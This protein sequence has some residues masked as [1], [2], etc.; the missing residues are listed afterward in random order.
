M[1]NPELN[2]KLDDPL[3]L[4]S[5]RTIKEI[6]N[7]NYPAEAALKV[8]RLT[9][10][11]KCDE[12]DD[13]YSNV[14]ASYQ[15]LITNLKQ[16]GE[17]DLEVAEMPLNATL[18][19]TK[20]IFTAPSSTGRSV[21]ANASFIGRYECDVLVKP[22]SRSQVEGFLQAFKN[23][24]PDKTPEEVADELAEDF[25]RKAFAAKK[26]RE[27]EINAN[28]AVKLAEIDKNKNL[29]KES[30]D[31]KIQKLNDEKATKLFKAEAEC[32]RK[33]MRKGILKYFYAG[34]NCY[35]E[36]GYAI[37]L[38]AK[39]G[40]AK[41]PYAPSN[42]TI[43]FAAA[44]SLKFYSYNLSD[45]GF[46]SLTTLKEATN[47]INK[48]DVLENWD[49]L[50]KDA[51][52]NR[53]VR[54]IITGNILAAYPEFIKAG[55]DS[56]NPNGK[57]FLGK[58]ITFTLSD[59]SKEKGILFPATKDDNKGETEILTTVP[60]DLAV[61]YFKK[62]IKKQS[63]ADMEREFEVNFTKGIKLNFL[64]YAKSSD[65]CYLEMTTPMRTKYYKE[66][67]NNVF[68]IDDY[69]RGFYNNGKGSEYKEDGRNYANSNINPLNGKLFDIFDYCKKFG[70]QIETTQALA[71]EIIGDVKEN[72]GEAWTPLHVDTSRIPESDY[73]IV[74]IPDLPKYCPDLLLAELQ[75]VKLHNVLGFGDTDSESEI[76]EFMLDSSA[77]DNK[78]INNLAPDKKIP[79]SVIEKLNK[80][81]M[82]LESIDRL[83]AAGFPVCKYKTQ[84]TV[85][86][87]CPNIN[88]GYVAGYKCLTINQNQSLGIRWAGIDSDKK[89]RIGA[90][91]NKIAAVREKVEKT[92]S[93]F[94]Y[95][96]SSVTSL[97]L[98]ICKAKYNGF[99]NYIPDKAIALA[100]DIVKKV[101]N[102]TKGLFFGYAHTICT[103]E[104]YF[105]PSMYCVDIVIL[106]IYE[107]N[108]ETFIRKVYNLSESEYKAKLAKYD[109]LEAEYER[110]RKQE[111]QERERQ[112]AEREK[113]LNESLPK[114]EAEFDKYSQQ[115]EKQHP[116]PNNF[117]K[118]NTQDYPKSG[119]IICYYKYPSYKRFIK[120]DKYVFSDTVFD[121]EA[122]LV[123]EV[124]YSSFGK[125][126]CRRCN[127]NGEKIQNDYS[128]YRGSEYQGG[129]QPNW[130]V[131]VKSAKK[132]TTTNTAVPAVGTSDLQIVDYSDKA[133]VLTGDTKPLKDQIKHLGGKFGSRFDKSKV[134]SGIG[135]LFPKTKLN[136]VQDFIN[137]YGKKTDTAI[138]PLLLKE[139]QLVKLHNGNGGGLSGVY[140]RLPNKFWRLED[141]IFPTDEKLKKI[142]ENICKSG[143]LSV[144]LLQQLKLY[145]NDTR[146]NINQISGTIGKDDRT[147]VG[148]LLL[149]GSTCGHQTSS[150]GILSSGR[151]AFRRRELQ[152]RL[153]L[154]FAELEGIWYKSKEDFITK[155]RLVIAKD[156]YGRD[157]EGTETKLYVAPSGN[158]V[159]K[160]L[161]INVNSNFLYDNLLERIIV[162]NLMF[163]DKTA[164]YIE[165]FFFDGNFISIAVSQPFI[166]HAHRLT[167]ETQQD[168]FFEQFTNFTRTNK[169]CIVNEDLVVYDLHYNNVLVDDNGEYYVIDC[170]AKFFRKDDLSNRYNYE[171]VKGLGSA[172]NWC[173]NLYCAI[174]DFSA[175]SAILH[176]DSRTPWHYGRT[177]NFDGKGK[178]KRVFK[179]IDTTPSKYILRPTEWINNKFYFHNSDYLDIA[180]DSKTWE[181]CFI[182]CSP[183]LLKELELVKLHNG[184]G[185]GLS[186]TKENLI[187]NFQQNIWKNGFNSVTLNQLD[188]LI[189]DIQN[190][191]IQSNIGRLNRYGR[192]CNYYIAVR[193]A[194][195]TRGEIGADKTKLGNKRN[196][197]TW[198]RKSRIRRQ[199]EL[200]TEFATLSG[201][202]L[203]DFSEQP[204][205]VVY[206][207][208][209]KYEYLAEGAEN[210]VYDSGDKDEQRKVIKV[211]DIP[212]DW[213]H[214]FYDDVAEIFER[215]LI[216]NCLF[217]NAVL[218]IVGFAYDGVFKIVLEQFYFKGVPPSDSEFDEFIKQRVGA[219]K[220]VMDFYINDDFYLGDFHDKN[221]IKDKNGNII[222]IDDMLAFNHGDF[223]GLKGFDFDWLYEDF[224]VGDKVVYIGKD[225]GNG[226][227]TK[228]TVGTIVKIHKSRKASILNRYDLQIGG[229]SK[230]CGFENIDLRKLKLLESEAKLAQIF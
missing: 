16:R 206:L 90:I 167:K 15:Q 221:V 164:L 97:R 113:S 115:W 85:H 211:I 8:S 138:S 188:F 141:R 109:E 87:I 55:D 77:Y 59:G 132:T 46:R 71:S 106:G 53:E 104:T 190:G 117:V 216:H 9:A 38:G 63:T 133:I 177:Y 137:R 89:R 228:G 62:Q 183:L 184:N 201:C 186:G 218:N 22:Y 2:E 203:N 39:I 3:N 230:V 26:V 99:I 162:H 1:D 91:A 193:A 48:T 168:K 139:L 49:S 118:C 204:G 205:N 130:F 70:L 19:G 92:A 75:L 223:K 217:Q 136:V 119:D 124:F 196:A 116:I 173:D 50:I 18:L 23:E 20:S 67:T 149:R 93:F 191:H 28:Y 56:G 172:E 160:F 80:V 146:R 194:I 101:N 81:G 122:E 88:H 195:I 145:S 65:V 12:Q 98:V 214:I 74:R 140:N 35:D 112:E 208:G 152:Q 179:L 11:L 64:I 60:I 37:C 209:K 121:V 33:R 180:V 58:L 155:N 171:G 175:K 170:Y 210:R 68:W 52:K 165:G 125:M 24:H 134:P 189:N 143:K 40:K 47:L 78:H 123:F 197:Q 43:E 7:G 207:N 163:G 32:N 111:I 83:S 212:T 10:T 72:E 199:T 222:V 4:T 102:N 105:K 148:A 14:M 158:L 187:Q 51:V 166:R 178:W 200:L 156:E 127:E 229:Y 45:D 135:W 185:G 220:K 29:D 95:R 181:N 120:E 86:G 176:P 44:S 126:C 34:R 153:L 182:K 157:I 226:Y 202:W 224:K 131:K 27:I 42:I 144:T 76:S 161:R 17:Y 213:E 66:F 31:I 174:H 82:T 96:D 129:F 54:R 36:F 13:F 128:T 169:T 84:V 73:K 69:G 94:Y 103:K 25:E 6:A 151:E 30:K 57:G 79:Y 215:I 142:Y 41:N 225:Y 147:Y 100:Q 154:Q 114:F 227:T 219:L 110:Q 108:I 107:N 21:F 5:D 159:Y 61:K 192:P 150:F 198:D